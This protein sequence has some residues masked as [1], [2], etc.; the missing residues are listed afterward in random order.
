MVTHVVGAGVECPSPAPR[1]SVTGSDWS[2]RSPPVGGQVVPLFP[3]PWYVHSAGEAERT[4]NGKG[5]L[6]EGPSSGTG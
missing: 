3:T 6:G 1:Q 4:K 2:L 5:L